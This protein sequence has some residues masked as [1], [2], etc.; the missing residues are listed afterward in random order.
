MSLCLTSGVLTI[1]LALESFTLA[2]EHSIEK[3]RWEEDWRIEGRRLHIVGARIK[4][5]GAGMEPPPD[6]VLHNGAWHYRPQLAPLNSVHLAN[7]KF[8]KDYELCVN[9][10]CQPLAGLIHDNRN[11]RDIG[12]V[13]LSVCEH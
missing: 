5:F 4:G 1:A 12:P 11:A 9:G 13:A 2:W 10:A 8:T 3:V 6:A 7:S